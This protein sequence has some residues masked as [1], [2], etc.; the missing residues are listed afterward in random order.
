MSLA[1][2]AAPFDENSNTNL[3]N[4]PETKFS[5]EESKKIKSKNLQH[6]IYLLY[7]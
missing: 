3:Y 4:F 5:K 1:M 6:K 2:Y 7:T